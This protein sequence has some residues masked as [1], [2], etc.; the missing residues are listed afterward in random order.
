MC[1]A[2]V[3]SP[4]ISR[5][6]LRQATWETSVGEGWNYG[7]ETADIA[8]IWRVPHQMKGS[9]TC[10]KSVT[11]DRRLYFPSEG[12]LRT[13][14]A[15]KIRRLRPGLNPRSWVPEASMLNIRPLKSRS[16]RLRLPNSVTSEVEGGRLS[17]LRTGRLY[18]RNILVLIF[19]RLSR[20]WA[21]GIVG[22]HWKNSHWQHLGSIP[23][24]SD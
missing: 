4:V 13:F 1:T 20:P 9:L 16:G 11:W 10:Q 12:M 8:V 23:G 19:K 15:W 24:L 17:A 14:S 21:H 18:P 22:C 3:V 7:W 5:G 6:A 2:F